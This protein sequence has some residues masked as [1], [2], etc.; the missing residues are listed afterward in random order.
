ME[1]RPLSLLAAE[2]HPAGSAVPGS[3]VAVSA[4]KLH[5]S[6][7]VIAVD[8]GSTERRSTALSHNSVAATVVRRH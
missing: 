7:N 4:S 6:E 3:M 8:F 1:C 5:I 2:K